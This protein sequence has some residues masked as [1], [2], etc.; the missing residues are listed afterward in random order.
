V[1]G[2]KGGLRQPK[3]LP[4]LITFPS[5]CLTAVRLFQLGRPV[6]VCEVSTGHLGNGLEPQQ[7]EGRENI[8]CGKCVF[9]GSIF[10]LEYVA[11]FGTG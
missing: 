8:S 1:C 3:N 10:C 2:I 4:L 11:D 5:S 7:T 6:P 9:Y